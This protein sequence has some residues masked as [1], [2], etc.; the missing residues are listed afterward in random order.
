MG[1]DRLKECM[2]VVDTDSVLIRL[3][4]L[5]LVFK[6]DVCNVLAASEIKYE[7]CTCV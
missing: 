7:C 4:C 6:F 3:V 5:L 1:G 2:D